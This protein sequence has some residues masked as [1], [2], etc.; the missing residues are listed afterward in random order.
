MK[1]SCTRVTDCGSLTHYHCHNRLSVCSGT[2][3]SRFG[4]SMLTRTS[5]ACCGGRTGYACLD[6][7][8][9]VARLKARRQAPGAASQTSRPTTLLYT[10][11]DSCDLPVATTNQARF[12][13]SW[14]A[15]TLYMPW[16][17]CR[18][19]SASRPLR[20]RKPGPRHQLRNH[21]RMPT[22]PTSVII[23]IRHSRNELILP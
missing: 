1:I 14:Y 19:V 2:L 9:A 3:A 23:R 10:P 13:S 12:P 22:F 6:M 7:I 18:L 16:R 17:S 8:G 20:N 21:A 5:P 4:K 11:P 15:G